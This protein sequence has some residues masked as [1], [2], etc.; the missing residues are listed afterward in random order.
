MNNEK[1]ILEALLELLKEK[2]LENVSPERALL[3]VRIEQEISPQT[4]ED[5]GEDLSQ[6]DY[7]DEDG[8]KSV[9]VIKE[10]RK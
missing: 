6:E 7:Y 8:D 1:L 3:T 9:T 4:K 2:R 5:I 10:D